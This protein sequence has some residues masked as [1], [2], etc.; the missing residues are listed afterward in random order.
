VDMKTR[1]GYVS[2]PILDSYQPLLRVLKLV[3]ETAFEGFEIYYYSA[4]QYSGKLYHAPC[5]M[6]R[7][8]LS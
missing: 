3:F 4:C 6:M 8:R 2:V 5:E 7:I 1:A